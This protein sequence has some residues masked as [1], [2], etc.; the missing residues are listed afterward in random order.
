MVEKVLQFIK[1]QGMIAPNDKI[2]VGVSGGADSICLLFMLLELKKQMPLELIVVHV[3]H[4]IR[5]EE[6]TQDREFVERVCEQNDT[7]Y[8]VYSYDVPK[9]AREEGKSLEEKGREVRYQAFSEML[10]ET[11]ANKIAVA[12]NQNDSVE[13]TLIHLCRGSGVKGLGGILPVRG[14]II[15]PLLC[16]SRPEIEQYLEDKHIPY[17][18]DSSNLDNAYTRNRVRNR[19]LPF[20]EGEV[21]P[22]SMTHILE[23]SEKMKEIE[24]FLYDEA[25]KICGECVLQES[26]GLL[27][28]E[29]G[30]RNKAHIMQIYAVRI[31]LEHTLPQ[32]K[33]IQAVHLE[34]VVGLFDKKVGKQIL[35]PYGFAARRTYEGILIEDNKG[36]QEGETNGKDLCTLSMNLVIKPD[37]IPDK[38]YTKWIDQEKING[39]LQLRTRQ[40]GDYI[41]VTANGGT[42]KIKDYFINEKVPKEERDSVLL[43]ADGSEIVWIVGYRLSERYKVTDETTKV[44]KV[45]MIGGKYN[46]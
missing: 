38:R 8:V 13:T 19:L 1:E 29:Q 21:N 18:I 16:V 20:L 9:L 23:F 39:D 22:K 44:L 5:G 43:L 10:Q 46:E 17:R 28:L 4:G 45:E 2:I 32:M 37:L 7:N 6:A 24:Q 31:C 40:T 12:H 3:E 30:L 42:K 36:E 26:K 34:Q 33:N 15:R 27:L 35:L 14:E 41:Q 11:N 25:Y